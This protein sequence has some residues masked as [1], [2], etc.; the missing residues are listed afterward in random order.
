MD[1]ERNEMIGKYSRL[2][3]EYVESVP[4]PMDLRHP[5]IMTL[6]VSAYCSSGVG[7]DVMKNVIMDS[8]EM[9]R[10]EY[11]KLQRDIHI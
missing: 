8:L 1:D 11:L 7:F 4:I 5:C 10:E 2:I 3:K 6:L 9:T